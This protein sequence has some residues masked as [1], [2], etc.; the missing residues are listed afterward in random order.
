MGSTP[1]PLETSFQPTTYVLIL[2]AGRSDIREE[3]Y[4]LTS[5]PAQLVMDYNP[6][7]PDKTDIPPLEDISDQPMSL[8]TNFTM[9]NL[10]PQAW[11]ISQI[12][13]TTPPDTTVQEVN[14]Y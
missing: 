7:Y 2:Y 5:I 4:Y 12:T 14:W 13:I 9:A 11:A 3:H 6:P 10:N 1:Q 8:Q